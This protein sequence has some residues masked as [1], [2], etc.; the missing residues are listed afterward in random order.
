[1]PGKRCTDS[2]AN[3]NSY[4]LNHLPEATHYSTDSEAIDAVKVCH[5]VDTEVAVTH[6]EVASVLVPVVAAE[7]KALDETTAT[8]SKEPCVRTSYAWMRL[9]CVYARI[10]SVT[11][12]S[13]VIF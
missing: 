2:L 1:M 10:Y 8:L 12:L 5:E 9:F 7:V 11:G 3:C 13:W 6:D 4:S